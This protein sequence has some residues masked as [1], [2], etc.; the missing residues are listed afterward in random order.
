MKKMAKS[1]MMKKMAKQMKDMCG[2]K[3]MPKGTPA[4]M[5]KKT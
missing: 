2:D 1:D 4:K 5:K 3:K